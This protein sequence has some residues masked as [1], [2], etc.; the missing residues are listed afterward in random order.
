MRR[1]RRVAGGV[2]GTKLPSGR[3]SINARKMGLPEGS[4]GFF[5][6][7]RLSTDSIRRYRRWIR[8]NPP[9]PSGSLILQGFLAC[10]R[11]RSD[12][13]RRR[14]HDGLAHRPVWVAGRPEDEPLA[15]RQTAGG[16]HP[17]AMY[18]RNS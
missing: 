2:E 13:S 7:R 10:A 8:E 11:R 12:V 9:E 17:A 6:Y 3:M 4:G 15:V 14:R 1:K 18:L 5:L 16:K